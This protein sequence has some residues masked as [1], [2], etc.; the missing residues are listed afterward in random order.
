VGGCAGGTPAA[1]EAGG[2]SAGRD[3]WGGDSSGGNGLAT[4]DGAGSEWT[5]GGKLYVGWY[6]NGALA[7]TG[8]GAVSSG[9]AQVGYYNPAGSTVVTV[10]GPGSAWSSS[11]EIDISAYTEGALTLSHGGAASAAN[12]IVVST[13][14]PTVPGSLNIGA[15]LAGAA[16]PAGPLNTPAVTLGPKGALN[17]NHTG[18]YAFDAQ[19]KSSSAGSGAVTQAAGV[20]TLT[21]DSSASY[22]GA[23]NVTGGTLNVQ[24]SIAS[25]SLT[26]VSSAATLAGA[27]AV[28]NA[29]LASGATLAP[30]DGTPGSAMTVHGNLAL[31]PGANLVASVNASAASLATVSGA[32]SIDG[33]HV[34][35]NYSGPPPALGKTYLL[36][37]ASAGSMTGSP[38]NS[39]VDLAGVIYTLTVHDQQLWAEVTAL[40]AAPAAPASIPTL[41][42]LML[43]ALGLLLAALAA[44]ARRGAR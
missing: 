38:A 20:T 13:L 30:G 36:I 3:G 9:D 23:V 1:G 8:G 39:T 19:L 26:A 14:S 43:A 24:G 7:I 29:T 10:D 18:A 6:A 25:A 41:T 2:V 33:I 12:G 28:G 40:P 16:T 17:F 35:L 11:G 42:P 15:P 5:I 21:A 44:W 22:T 32:A 4:V 27:G 31:A 37:D 34:T